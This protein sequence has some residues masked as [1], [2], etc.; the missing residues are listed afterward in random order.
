MLARSV[1]PILIVLVAARGAVGQP[2]PDMP[3]TPQRSGGDSKIPISMPSNSEVLASEHPQVSA[4]PPPLALEQPIDPN[5]YVCG[6]G[7]VF[8][9]DFWG[10]Q[11]FRLRLMADLEGR[12]FI[13]KV[14]FV[15][16]A[17][18]TLSAVRTAVKKK[19]RSTYPG[20]QFELTLVAPRTFTVHVADNVK[21]PGAY[22]TNAVE[23]VSVVL[24]R[25]GGPL[26]TG[27]RRRISIRHRDGTSLVADL[28]LYEQTG[29]TKYNPTLLDGDIVSVPFAEI[30][31]SIGGAVRRP[32]T[33]E[34]VADK[35]SAELLA[36]AGG[37]ASNVV[38]DLPVRIVRRNARQQETFVNIAFEGAGI[39]SVPLQNDDRVFVR[40]SD[41]VQRTVQLIGAVTGS[42]TL[43]AATSS[44]RLPYV[45]G[46]TVM[47]I[48]ERAGGIKAPGDL[49]RSYIMRP[50]AGKEPALVA[51]DLDALLVRRDF[52]ADRKVELGDTI[53]IP[54]MR[55]S[56]LV[57]GAVA[58]AGLYNYN[59]QFSISEYIAHAGG[60]TRTAR[61]MDE[62]RLIDESG[63]THDFRR[64]LKPKPGDAILVPER[65]FSRSEVAQL[66]LAGAGLLL[67]GV[68]ITI[69]ATR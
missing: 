36:L 11:N 50:R 12:A 52:K 7:D 15:D 37:L 60:M 66:V 46:D 29:D 28:V 22:S 21:T 54:P 59:P 62:V 14:G 17:G 65:N 40:G 53:V 16:V 6:A 51:L 1:L 31:A 33:Y 67:S 55:Y 23:R 58:R 3:T 48:L 8:E 30:T 68:A 38:R 44:R 10:Q 56:V 45:E 27:S 39:A 2:Q 57:E 19:V 5:S 61:S 49:R 63:V 4:A 32:G 20:L 43:D 25:A 35:T 13:E 34:L 64:D 24:G 69:A 47:S 42:D 26:P 41:E 18:K 9:L